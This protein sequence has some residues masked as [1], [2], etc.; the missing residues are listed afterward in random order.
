MIRAKDGERFFTDF[1]AWAAVLA[2]ELGEKFTRQQWDILLALAQGWNGER[3]H[4]EPIEKVFAKIAFGDFFF[5][6]LVGG[7]D[8][9]HIDAQGLGASDRGE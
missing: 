3:H 2:A 8:E 7:G 9:T 1:D 4:V 6:V 5:E